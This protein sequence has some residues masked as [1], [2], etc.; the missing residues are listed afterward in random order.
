MEVK[1]LAEVEALA[2]KKLKIFKQ[3]RLRSI[4][5]SM[6]AS[7]FIGF[8]VIVAFK[9][10][11][12]FFMVDSPMA[13]PMAALVFGAAIILIAYGGGDLFTGNTFYFTYA[14]LRK[15]IPWS[16]VFKVWGTSYVGNIFGAATFALLIYLT[17]LFNSAEVNG[18]LLNV[19]EHKVHA[20]IS[21]LFFPSYSL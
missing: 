12:F 20:P 19:A 8:G 2:L 15:K 16:D 1:Y 14:A 6:V 13:Y 11:N 4:L 7:M 18:F 21:E 9:T 10:G 3:S 17:G 5:R